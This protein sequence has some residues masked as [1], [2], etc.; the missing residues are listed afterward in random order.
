MIKE[1]ELWENISS[2]KGL[3]P[4]DDTLDDEYDYEYDAQENLNSGI[5]FD[6]FSKIEVDTKEDE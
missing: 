1:E 4:I 3:K 6:R 2:G 5:R